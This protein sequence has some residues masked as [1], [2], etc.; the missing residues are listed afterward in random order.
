MPGAASYQMYVWP[1]TRAAAARFWSLIRKNYGAGDPEL[2]EHEDPETAW[3]DPDLLFSQTCGLPFR[4]RLWDRV[5]LLG[6]LDYGVVG[7]PPGYYRSCIVV[8]ADDPRNC[9]DAFRGA[10]LARNSASSQSGW[11]ALEA[12]LA[13]TGAGFTFRDRVLDTGGH[14]ASARA[15]ADGQADLASLDAVTWRFLQRYDPVVARL[16]ILAE[17]R[18]SP[19]L[20]L[21]TGRDVD[22]HP[23]FA[24]V[25]AAIAHLSPADRETLGIKAIVRIPSLVYL[26]EP[27]PYPLT[28]AG[29]A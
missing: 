3:T 27:L 5:T 10:T 19:G 16:R 7:C 20:P 21:I 22:P 4:H 25:E 29:P 23:L 13:E 28:R 14:A 26:A 6:T 17:T 11:A 2:T 1:E 8:R 18:P 15:V 9:V 12:H 24:A